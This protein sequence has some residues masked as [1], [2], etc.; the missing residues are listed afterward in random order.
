MYL[1]RPFFSQELSC[2]GVT[3]QAGRPPKEE[4]VCPTCGS[5]TLRRPLYQNRTRAVNRYTRIPGWRYCTTCK[6]MV[7]Q[8]SGDPPGPAQARP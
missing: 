6:A 2:R 7:W 4:I 5:S 1:R 8:G 3:G